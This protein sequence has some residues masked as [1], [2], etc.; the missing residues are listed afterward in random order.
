MLE[1]GGKKMLLDFPRQYANDQLDALVYLAENAP[2][3]GQEPLS[4][5]DITRI[6]DAAQHES[7]QSAQ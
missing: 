5:P 6:I 7:N 2:A 3:F 1:R 4:G